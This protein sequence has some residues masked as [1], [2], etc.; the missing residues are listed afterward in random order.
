MSPEPTLVHCGPDRG[1][2]RLPAAR[3]FAALVLDIDLTLTLDDSITELVRGLRV[4]PAELAEFG[5]ACQRGT[6]TQPVADRR[7]LALLRAG[8]GLLRRDQLLRIFR[9]IR[10]RPA[11]LPLVAA[12]RARGLRVCLI[13][14]SY[15][16]YV[17]L[18]ARRL[19]VR[20]YYPNVR[21]GF[22]PAGVLRELRFSM[23][24]AGTKHRQLHEF[25]HRHG[26]RPA[27][28]LVVGDDRNDAELFACTGNGVLLRREGNRELA[29]GAWLAADE[30]AEI[31]GL[32]RGSG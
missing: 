21:L 26:L 12:A 1:P 15:D 31:T 8:Q 3:S 10:L 6:L 17:R 9:A 18:I 29:A 14:S 19:G 23:D 30:L 11:A 32:L 7:L 22:G 13:S 27:E 5:R 24:L 20:E 2:D 25:C 16:L 28:V 4:P